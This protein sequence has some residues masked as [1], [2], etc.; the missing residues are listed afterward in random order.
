[1]NSAAASN[2]P[3]DPV[4]AR[5]V[6]IAWEQLRVVF[7]VVLLLLVAIVGRDFWSEP[8]F[9]R[10]VTKAGVLAN[11][12]YCIGPVLEGYLALAGAPRR[13][14]R[15]ALFGGGLVLACGLAALVVI[16][17]PLRVND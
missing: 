6:F 2:A 8:G 4:S 17:W 7:N 12:C 1:M 3:T 14:L 9:V 13:T 5:A 16:A 11:V 10:F 15:I